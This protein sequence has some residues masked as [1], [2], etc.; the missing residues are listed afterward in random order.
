[1]TRRL[2]LSYLAVALFVL[3]VLEV[4]LGITYARS[5]LDRLTTAVERDAQVI[6]SL[7][8]DQ[9][10]F[11]AGEVDPRLDGYPRRTGSRVLIVDRDGR[12]VYDSQDPGDPAALDRDYGTRPEI[13]DALAGSR[14][15]GTRPSETLGHDLLYVAVP[16]ASGGVVHGAVRITYPTT[17]LAA[18]IVRNWLMLGAIAVVVLLATALVGAAVARWVTR[19]TRALERGVARFADGDLEVQVPTDRGPP[20]VRELSAGFNEMATRLAQLIRAQ[21]SFVSD[22]SHQLRSPLTALR[23]ELEELEADADDELAAGIAR[24]IGETHRL[25]RLVTDLLAL[26]TAEADRPQPTIQDATAL[27]RARAEAWTPLAQDHHVD[28]QLGTPPKPAWV[29]VVPG[30]LEQ[31]V[32]NLIDNALEAAP[33]GSSVHLSARTAANHVEIHV[34]DEGAGLDASVRQRAFDRFWRGPDARPGAGTGL[35]LAIARQLALLSGGNVELRPRHPHGTDATII[36][37]M[38]P[39]PAT[40]SPRSSDGQLVGP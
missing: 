25:T 23:L 39:P 20:E 13:V 40:T 10:Q 1:M 30:H 12:T 32:D 31:I 21:R 26:A 29:R 37:V 2:V 9:L 38:G 7:V 36:L 33:A 16:V 6:G 19:P 17:A 3:L 22:A 18:R 11:G 34:E 4:P 5:E 35:G 14:S 28:L 24:A 27:L 15:S 8:E